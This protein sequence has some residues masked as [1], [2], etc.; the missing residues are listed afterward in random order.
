MG[1][2]G[3]R[4]MM[5]NGFMGPRMMGMGGSGP[6]MCTAMAGHIEGVLAYLKAELKITKPRS[7]LEILRRRRARQ[8]QCDARALH[9][10]DEQRGASK[11][12]LPDRLDQHEQS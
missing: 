10:D 3:P 7:R 8:Q 12:S 9:H 5:G 1:N 4:G 11:V 6:A 2:W